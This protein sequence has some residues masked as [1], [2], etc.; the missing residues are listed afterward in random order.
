VANG[1][2]VVKSFRLYL[3]ERVYLT[4]TGW[5]VALASAATSAAV[6]IAF[7]GRLVDTFGPGRLV[8][9]IVTAAGLAV[10][11]VGVIV[12]HRFGCPVTRRD[13]PSRF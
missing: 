2:I 6:G 3:G 4:G 11:G 7:A 1:E 5:A 9:G 10:W 8:I 12:C 13:P